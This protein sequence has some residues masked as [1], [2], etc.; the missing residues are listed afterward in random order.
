MIAIIC[1]VQKAAIMTALLSS[2][3]LAGCEDESSA[4]YYRYVADVSIGGASYHFDQY[5]AC[6]QEAGLS[7]ADGK[8]HRQWK[9]RGSGIS[10]FKIDESRFVMFTPTANCGAPAPYRPTK[11]IALLDASNEVVKLIFL[12]P[13]SIGKISVEPVE[14]RPRLIGPASEVKALTASILDHYQGRFDR[15]TVRVIPESIWAS[16]DRTSAYFR[17]LTGVVAAKVGEVPP[18][19]GWPDTV[20]RFPGYLERTYALEQG[21]VV[22]L[23]EREVPYRQGAFIRGEQDGESSECYYYTKATEILRGG[24]RSPYATVRYRDVDVPVTVVQEVYDADA[25]TIL[26]FAH[27]SWVNLKTMLESSMQP[28]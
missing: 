14:R 15:V 5:L 10:A 26:S 12:P 9:T 16:S 21:K 1:R 4:V 25:R 6:V 20:V 13:E 8:I 22:G 23:P 17:S 28:G 18:V 3:S 19:S 2:L 27:F 11:N 7:E 24:S